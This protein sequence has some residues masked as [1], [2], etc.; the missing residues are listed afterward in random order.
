[1]PNPNILFQNIPSATPQQ[2]FQGVL[3]NQA[4]L[5]QFQQQPMQNRL[6]QAQTEGQEQRNRAVGQQ[7]DQEYAKFA[8]QDLATDWGSIK[9]LIAKGDMQ[10][11][12]VAIAQRIDK[13]LKRKGDPS[14]TIELRDRLNSGQITPEQAIAEVD[15]ALEGARQAGLFGG[16]QVDRSYKPDSRTQFLLGM[17]YRP[18][19]PE[20]QS[21]ADK[22]F[23]PKAGAGTQPPAAIQ[24]WEAYQRMS[25]E[26]RKAFN[27]MK[28]GAGYSSTTEKQIFGASDAYIEDNAAAVNYDD[29]AQRYQAAEGKISSGAVAGVKEWLKEYTGN[30]D[31]LT[32]LR[33][34]WT[35]IKASEVVKNLP[36]GAASDADIK[37]AL[38]GFISNNA[39]PAE[40]AAKLRGMAKLR[41]MNAEYSA[42]KADYL[43][44][45]RN[46]GGL[47]KAWAE[48]A[49]QAGMN[50]PTT[51]SAQPRGQQ[52]AQQ[53]Q[54]S[55]GQVIEAGGKRYRVTGGDPNDPDVEEIQ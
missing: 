44:E 3:Q 49:Q 14:D 34:D 48:K 8:L 1:M 29:L 38:E 23:G 2:A 46:P 28:R 5:N 52:P 15:G 13:I 11:A 25:P 43:S 36:P 30:E 41:R 50:Q 4:A 35:Q 51:S 39:D 31:E 32:A 33:K 17:G 53:G 37:M 24:E 18:G 22:Y 54:Y 47:R 55:P 6:L 20:Y 42:F 7:M 26:E 19:T 12:N 27:E 16:M 9:P 40:V 45:N 21:A 10:N